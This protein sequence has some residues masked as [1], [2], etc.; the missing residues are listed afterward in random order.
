MPDKNGNAAKVYEPRNVALDGD[1][2]DSIQRIIDYDQRD[3]P[4]IVRGTLTDYKINAMLRSLTNA[5]VKAI[6]TALSAKIER[7]TAKYAKENNLTMHDAAKK[8]GFIAPD[9]PEQK[10]SQANAMHVAVSN[11]T[12]QQTQKQHENAAKSA[13]AS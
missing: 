5:R 9:T 4:A 6:D 13:K 7:I 12:G 1:I 3:M 11:E 10:E 2:L 8:L